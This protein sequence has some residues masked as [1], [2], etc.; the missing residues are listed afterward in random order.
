MEIKFAMV[1]SPQKQRFGIF[2]VKHAL[3]SSSQN[4][5]A[6]IQEFTNRFGE[7]PVLLAYHNPSDG[8]LG[9][10]GERKDLLAHVAQFQEAQ[11]PWRT[12]EV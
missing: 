3:V 12:K 11:I 7:M 6:A 4:I 1:M 2:Y 5:G 10:I 9:Y 8:K